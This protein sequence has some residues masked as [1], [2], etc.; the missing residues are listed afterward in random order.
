[1]RPEHIRWLVDRFP[2][3]SVGRVAELIEGSGVRLVFTRHRNTKL[4][5]FRVGRG[6]SGACTITL[7]GDMNRYQTLVTFLHEYAHYKVH[8]KHTGKVKPHGREWKSEFTALM[9]D[10]LVEDIFPSQL[11]V[12]LRN[13]MC[14]PKA[15]AFADTALA[16]AMSEYD[17]DGYVSVFVEDVPMGEVFRIKRNGKRFVKTAKLRKRYKCRSLDNGLYYLVSPMAEVEPTAQL[18]IGQKSKS[19]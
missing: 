2:E 1:M 9:S 10:Y 8:E 17:N 6:V 3:K 18:V 12:V 13:Y 5:D 14:N 4:G 11:L 7:N 15:G 19:I 16:K